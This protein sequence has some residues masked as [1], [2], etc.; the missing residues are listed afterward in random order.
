MHE[1]SVQRVL[2]LASGVRDVDRPSAGRRVRQGAFHSS[3]LIRR[4]R[5][6][7]VW[8]AEPSRRLVVYTAPRSALVKDI[9]ALMFGVP[10][11]P[12]VVAPD[13]VEA[14]LQTD[15]L[16]RKPFHW[17]YRASSACHQ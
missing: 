10:E 1:D 17:R 8:Y 15:R 13:L 7:A 4:H 16:R 6:R 2:H 11:Q 3:A 5:A 12:P 14:S 9:L